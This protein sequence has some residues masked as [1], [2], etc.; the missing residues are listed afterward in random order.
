MKLEP[1]STRLS[2]R[3]GARLSRATHSVIYNSADAAR[4]HEALGYDRLK[5]VVIPN[6]FD[7][8]RF[9]PSASARARF[10]Q[11]HGLSEAHF[12]IG[13]VARVHQ[14]K[15]YCDLLDAAALFAKDRPHARF[16]LIGKGCEPRAQPLA[17]WVESRGLADRVIFLGERSDLETLYPAFDVSALASITESFPNVLGESMACAVPCAA[18]DVGAAAE[19]IGDTGRV[20]SAR[21]PAE[22]CS[23]LSALEHLGETGRRKIGLAARRRIVEHFSLE[24]V[25]ARFDQVSRAAARS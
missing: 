14:H 21:A 8:T 6:G 12:V 23:A 22:L 9:A 10:R 24:S 15:G 11:Q 13:V 20:V 7:T 18:T 5:T 1:L 2:I 3:A 25:A 4:H 19:L 17:Q 16:V